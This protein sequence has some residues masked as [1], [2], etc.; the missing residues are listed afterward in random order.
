MNIYYTKNIQELQYILFSA[1]KQNHDF[2]LFYAVWYF[3]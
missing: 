3:F 2:T 1:F